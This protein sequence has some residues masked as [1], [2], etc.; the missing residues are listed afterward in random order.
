MLVFWYDNKIAW[1]SDSLLSDHRRSEWEA[2]VENEVSEDISTNKDEVWQVWV[3]DGDID[4]QY[5]FCHREAAA[6]EIPLGI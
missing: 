1:I 6:A 4:P 3:Q 2:F 5:Q